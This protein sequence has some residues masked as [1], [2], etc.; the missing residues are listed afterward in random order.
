[1]K[2]YLIKTCFNFTSTT[3]TVQQKGFGNTRE[4]GE[5]LE[6]AY[7]GPAH[8][9]ELAYTES[10]GGG[11]R[12]RSIARKVDV[13]KLCVSAL[14]EFILVSA[15]CNIEDFQGFSGVSHCYFRGRNVIWVGYCSG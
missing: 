4:K 6:L 10:A 9:G 15:G 11:R 2:Y 12:F 8:A 3:F 1:M 13:M 5:L 7:R 14:F